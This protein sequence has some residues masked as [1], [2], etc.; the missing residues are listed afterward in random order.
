MS[1]FKRVF[2]AGFGGAVTDARVADLLLEY[3]VQVGRLGTT[4]SVTIPT[5]R[6]GRLRRTSLL[7]GPATQIVV[8]DD[9]VRTEMVELLSVEE[10]RSD[11]GRRILTLSQPGST[12]DIEQDEGTDVFP[13]LDLGSCATGSAGASPA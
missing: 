1:G 9:D 6:H 11:L 13:D 8:I 10:V 2:I 12:R 3:A 7:L 4:D 5:I